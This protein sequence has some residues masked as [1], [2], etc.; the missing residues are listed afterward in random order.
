M[1]RLLY[2]TDTHIRGTTPR[3]RTDDFVS[4]ISDKMNE[5][6]RIAR[7]EKVDAVLHGG[8]LFDRPDLSPAVVREFARLLRRLEVPVYTVAGNHDIFG[9]NPDTVDR[10]M[11]GLL[12][13]FGTVRLIRPG[14]KVRLEG[15]GVTVQLTGQPFHYDLDK[16]DPSLDYSVRNESGADF[17]IHMVHGMAVDRPLPEGVPHTMVDDLWSEDVDVLLTGHYH[18]GFPVKHREGRYIINPGA[19]ARI[20]NHPSEIRR[21]P[22]VAVLEL[23]KEISVR[24]IRIACAAPGEAVLDRS[25]L[26]K[27]AFREE[28]M[29]EFVR[30]LRDDGEFRALAVQEIIEEIAGLEKVEDEVKHE[31]LRRIAVVQ[32][33]LGREGG[34][35]E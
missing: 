12:D 8:D 9:H 33:Q 29:N 22:Q 20:N 14:E 6:I 19:L 23:G 16:R 28:R 10:S 3:S 30:V 32:E 2:M 35:G 15:E 17:C 31:A 11:L 18:A 25:Y 4:A 1:L 5:V 24:L 7:R 34:P 21:H 13:A 26:E 27:A